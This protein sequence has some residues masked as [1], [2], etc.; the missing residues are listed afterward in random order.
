MTNVLL[1]LILILLMLILIMVAMGPKAQAIMK[2]GLTYSAGMFSIAI[3]VAFIMHVA[4][5]W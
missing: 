3:V 2:E 5:G 4:F 1:I